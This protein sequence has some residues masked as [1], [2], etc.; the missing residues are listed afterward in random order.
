MAER[1]A[2]DYV[3]ARLRELGYEPRLDEFALPNGLT[4]INVVA[5]AAGE[6][7]SRSLL[8][9]AHLDSKPPSPGANDNA[10]GCG[11]LLELARVLAKNP[12][13]I[14]V[15]MVFWG[16]EEFL[17]QGTDSHHLGS[18]HHAGE[19]SDAGRDKLVGAVSIDM[20]GVGSTFRV[21]TM[22]RGPQSLRRM[23]LLDA[24]AA[25]VE[26]SFLKDRGR[27]GSIDHEP[28]ELRGIP[29]V[30]LQWR[31]DLDYHTVR[32]TAGRLETRPMRATGEF[33]IGF[34]YRLDAARIQ[35][36]DGGR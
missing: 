12:P 3:A 5:V 22:E 29:A 13:P 10:S 20:V 14:D 1:R 7:G 4:S 2:A 23:M 21:R 9:G 24:R 36:L 28:Y 15:E 33:V 19:L 17:P 25:R 16:C 34:I 35:A 8:L 27:T 32:D 31:K 26:L 11:L 6:D 30:W 18:R